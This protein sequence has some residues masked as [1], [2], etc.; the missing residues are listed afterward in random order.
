METP[1]NN[2]TARAYFK[3]MLITLV[4][5]IM[6]IV[7]AIVGNVARGHK[8]EYQSIQAITIL[9]SLMIPYHCCTL[10]MMEKCKLSFGLSIV[11]G[12]FSGII[13]TLAARTGLALSFLL[14]S[15][16]RN[17]GTVIHIFSG[18]W[19]LYLWMALLG[20]VCMLIEPFFRIVLHRDLFRPQK[21]SSF[22]VKYLPSTLFY[23]YV[24]RKDPPWQDNTDL[25][26]KDQ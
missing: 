17:M 2:L 23:K 24:L 6:M 13:L 22:L 4:V 9:V 10:F 12:F 20:I 14:L 1:M 16:D 15:S 21:S 26:G 7:C 5:M 19:H 25:D 3:S 11:T 8:V 18:F